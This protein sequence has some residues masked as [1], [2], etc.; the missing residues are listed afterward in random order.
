[1]SYIAQPTATAGGSHTARKHLRTG[2]E[3]SCREPGGQEGA[4][5]RPSPQ[6][7]HRAR[8]SSHFCPRYS[9]T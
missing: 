9:P 8:A 4:G 7:L 3:R 6:E 5:P 2:H 1:M